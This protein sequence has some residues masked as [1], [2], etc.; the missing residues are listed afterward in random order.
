MEN[1]CPKCNKPLPE[2]AAFCLHCFTDL[3]TF[4]KEK[5]S[6][7]PPVPATHKPKKILLRYIPI[8]LVLL[9]IF[10]ICIYALKVSNTNDLKPAG[11]TIIKA[12]ETIPLTNDYGENV[13]KNNGEQVFEIIDV[14]Q[15]VTITTTEK[16]NLLDKLFNNST[17]TT[18]HNK[19]ESSSVKN[20]KTTQAQT[21]LP[22]TTVQ[23][24]K[25]GQTGPVTSAPNTTIPQGTTNVITQ[26][27]GETTPKT[28]SPTTTQADS[29]QGTTPITDFEYSVSESGKYV[30]ITKYTG[31]DKHVTIPAVIN[32]KYV[33]SIE[34]NT[35]QNNATVETISFADD[36]N[37]PYLWVNSRCINNCS[38]LRVINFPDTDLG[39]V[40]NF[41]YNCLKVEKITLKNNQYRFENGALYY[42]GGKG[43]RLRYFCP[44]ANVTSFTLPVWST[45]FEGACNLKEAAYLKNITLHKNTLYFPDQTILPPTLENIYVE[46]GCAKGFDING[47]AFSYGTDCTFCAYPKQNKTTD[48]TLPDNTCFYSQD[49]ENDYLKT[50]RIP[51]TAQ[52]IF[53]SFAVNGTCFKNLQ[54][55][56]IQD[57]Q[58]NQSTLMADARVDNIYVY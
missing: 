45:G 35:F 23:Q 41:A 24:I 58:P 8:A 52:I 42:S 28:T 43:W 51:K 1:K 30:T 22:G 26:H 48:L 4:T 18:A 31:N 39:I 47:I 25:P 32:S 36:S 40:N 19:E 27:P 12:T 55:L 15:I 16:Q 54:N 2:E 7:I 46:D 29:N 49:I 17:Q 10:G 9:L 21:I 57:G 34:Q 38:N 5:T 3:K 13:T 56:Y 33:I 44:A 50:L 20:N 53:P 6:V 11:T 14:T 37:R